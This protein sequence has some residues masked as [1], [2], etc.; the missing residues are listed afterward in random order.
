MPPASGGGG[1]DAEG[2][3]GAPPP[4]PPPPPLSAAPVADALGEGE[5][6]PVSE[7]ESLPLG[8]SVP[9]VDGMAGGVADVL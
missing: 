7:R 5:G 3:G 9:V 4:P 6:A 8:V 2:E 1:G